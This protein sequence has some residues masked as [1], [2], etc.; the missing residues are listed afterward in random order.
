MNQRD[1]SRKKNLWDAAIQ[2]RYCQQ[3]W[4]LSHTVKARQSRKRNEL[5]ALISS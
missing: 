2:P 1:D 4:F 5:N 3:G